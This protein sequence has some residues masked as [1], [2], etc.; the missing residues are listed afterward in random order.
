M[1]HDMKATAGRN[2][3][4]YMM[5]NKN[6]GPNWYCDDCGFNMGPNLSGTNVPA[7]EKPFSKLDLP[8]YDEEK[9]KLCQHIFPVR[10]NSGEYRCFTCGKNMEYPDYLYMPPPTPDQKS[11]LQDIR[12]MEG[13]Y[14]PE[15][16]IGGPKTEKELPKPK[17]KILTAVS[18]DALV[19]GLNAED[20]EG[21]EL[22]GLCI[23]SYND[24][25]FQGI[26]KRKE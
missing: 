14:D 25:P 18:L 21:W 5:S 4:H 8:A 12:D 19:D 10:L 2:C 15:E 26:L 17:Y 11:Y 9:A 23:Y 16:I 3:K 6:G 1:V 24:H 22:S 7:S 13:K 20:A